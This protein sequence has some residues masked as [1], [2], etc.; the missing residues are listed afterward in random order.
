M[1]LRALIAEHARACGV[2]DLTIEPA[3]ARDATTTRFFSHRAGD[4]G[5]QLGVLIAVDP[6]IGDRSLTLSN[7]QAQIAY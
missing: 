1:D 2:A 5:R 6:P 7:G 4:A 3:A